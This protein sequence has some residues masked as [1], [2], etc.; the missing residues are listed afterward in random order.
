MAIDRFRCAIADVF[1]MII[2]YTLLQFFAVL[3]LWLTAYTT[4]DKTVC[5]FYGRPA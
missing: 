2:I 1:L 5:S 3:E 4:L